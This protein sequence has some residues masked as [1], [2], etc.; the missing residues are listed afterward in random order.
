MDIQSLLDLDYL[1]VTK[2]VGSEDFLNKVSLEV[3]GEKMLGALTDNNL[4]LLPRFQIGGT[5]FFW[6]GD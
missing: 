2:I 1:G 5:K 4:D 6:N 3:S